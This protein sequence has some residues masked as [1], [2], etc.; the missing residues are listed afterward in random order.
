M[1][2]PARENRSWGILRIGFLVTGLFFV[3]GCQS[4]QKTTTVRIVSS[5]DTNQVIELS[6]KAADDYA[7][8]MI[9]IEVAKMQTP[10]GREDEIYSKLK[11]LVPFLFMTILIAGVAAWWTQSKWVIIIAIA[12][13]LGLG[14]VFVIGAWLSWIK[15]GMLAVAIAVVLWRSGIY[16]RER[17]KVLGVNN[18]TVT[19]QGSIIANAQ[20]NAVGSK[21]DAGRS[22]DQS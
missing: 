6:G 2:S 8:R 9:Q 7:A 17:D 14:L 12:A 5:A 13:A 19:R 10:A 3:A 21:S 16:Q 4:S 15:W 1:Y 11:D 22:A 18:G 20:A